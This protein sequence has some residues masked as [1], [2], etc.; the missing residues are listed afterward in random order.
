MNE[1]M[2]DLARR[3]VASPHWRWMPGMLAKIVN[4]DSGR[5]C[6]RRG[7]PV[8]CHVDGTIER[9]WPRGTTRDLVSFCGSRRWREGPMLPDLTD[10]ATLGCLLALVRDVL[11]EPLA[12]VEMRQ[13]GDTGYRAI[14]RVPVGSEGWRVVGRQW[15]GTS[16]CPAAAEADVL[17]VALESASEG[18]G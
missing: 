11:G 8:V 16:R 7:E 17:L 4:G 12:S 13:P 3:A 5:V 1:A 15:W 6:E 9:P 14:L 2:E 10:P 18:V